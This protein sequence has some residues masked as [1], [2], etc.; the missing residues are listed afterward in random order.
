MN[1]INVFI[2]FLIIYLF[3]S[4]AFSLSSSSYLIAN[5]A[6]SF[7]DYEEASIYFENSTINDFSENDLEKKLIVFVLFK[8]TDNVS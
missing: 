5:S 3:T 4:K 7:F 8:V 6:V 1:K 2:I